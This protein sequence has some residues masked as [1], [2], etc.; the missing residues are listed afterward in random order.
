MPP[1]ADPTPD[2]RRLPAL[3]LLVAVT[4]AAAMVYLHGRVAD[5]EEQLAALSSQDL[6]PEPSTA[7]RMS[8]PPASSELG[9]GRAKA[10]GRAK[11]ARRATSG[12]EGGGVRADRRET[13]L[14]QDREDLR[15]E[16]IEQFAQEHGLDASEQQELRE[17][18]QASLEEVRA[19]E[20][21]HQ[22]GVLDDED[23]R[24]YR[25]DQREALMAEVALLIGE[26]KA[27]ALEA[28]LFRGVRVRAP[29]ANEP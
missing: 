16:R 12:G 3:L 24:T 19:L 27:E 9:V 11:G 7:P 1:A 23:L 13:Q 20:A 21:D 25:E 26:E 18:M 4:V 6:C 29:G 15:A 10:R 2:P 8:N 28:V 22:A 17:L 5:L 14:T